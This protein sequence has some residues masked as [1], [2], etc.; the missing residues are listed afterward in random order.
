MLRSL[1]QFSNHCL[2]NPNVTVEDS[3]ENPTNKSNPVV[4]GE[5]DDKKGQ[6]RTRTT[7][8]QDW[9]AADAVGKTTPEHARQ[10]LCEGEGGYKEASIERGTARVTDLEVLDHNP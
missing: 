10:G 2:N 8:K 9:L 6:Q 4:S 7:E 3:S 1:N 5:T